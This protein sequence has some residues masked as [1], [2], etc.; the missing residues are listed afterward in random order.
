MNK[1]IQLGNIRKGTKGFSNP[2]TGR[3]YSQY[4]VSPTLNTCQGGGREPKVLVVTNK[5][6]LNPK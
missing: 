1:I 4:G 2:Q 3:V 5:L 6:C